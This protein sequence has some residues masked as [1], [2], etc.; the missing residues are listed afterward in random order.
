MFWLPAASPFIL[1]IEQA[2]PEFSAALTIADLTGGEPASHG[3]EY[4]A[5]GG[6]GRGIQ[7]ILLE[8]GT[9]A[10]I[11]V[12]IPLDR[13]LPVRLDA[14]E[15]LWCWLTDQTAEPPGTLPP[16]RRARLVSTLRALDGRMAGASTREIAGALFGADRIPG[17]PEWK[18]HDLRSR[19]KR[20]IASGL[21]LMNGGYRELLR[22]PRSRSED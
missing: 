10:P 2:P 5:L 4:F 13:D 20:L 17:G 11:G 16:Q 3:S 9:V 18:A 1:S 22:P 7:L 12:L 8:A 14:A 15:R 6:P 19:A 21:A